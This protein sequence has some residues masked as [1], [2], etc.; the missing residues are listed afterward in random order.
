MN[1]RMDANTITIEQADH[2][3]LAYLHNMVIVF[4]KTIV[5]ITNHSYRSLNAKQREE[6]TETQQIPKA[7]GRNPMLLCQDVY[8]LLIVEDLHEDELKT[9]VTEIIQEM[10]Q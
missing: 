5:L 3:P 10:N 6:S 4:G 2:S 7:P 1:L 8:D 9:Q